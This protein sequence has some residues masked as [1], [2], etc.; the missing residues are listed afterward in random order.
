MRLYRYSRFA[1]AIILIIALSAFL[2][3]CGEEEVDIDDV[4]E[5]AVD[6]AEE[7]MGG[8]GGDIDACA[9]VTQQDASD[10]FEGD[11]VKNTST[12]PLV[13][14]ECIWSQDTDMASQLLQ[15]QIYDGEQFYADDPEAEPFDLGDKGK[16]A[17]DEFAGIDIQ[18]VQDGMT[19]ALSYFS[20]GEGVPDIQ[21]KVGDMKSLAEKVSGEL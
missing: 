20:F 8:D 3:S 9:I 5:Q 14:G 15:I 1:V 4:V 21:S 10:I 11:A 6:Q 17:I 16:I 13:L 2:A 19:V 18:W 7:Q 12:A